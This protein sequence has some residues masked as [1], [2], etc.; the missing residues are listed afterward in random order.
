MKEATN[1]REELNYFK[2]QNWNRHTEGAFESI[3]KVTEQVVEQG[4][5]TPNVTLDAELQLTL[6]ERITG[7]RTQDMT[8]IFLMGL[9][10]GS[11]LERDIPVDTENERLWRE[12]E[13]EL[14]E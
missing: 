2:Q 9:M 11:A 1:V 14:P 5:F 10:L 13:Y 8:A 4:K 3:E 6:K 12:R 7:R